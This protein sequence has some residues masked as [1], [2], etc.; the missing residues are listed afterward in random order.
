M[1]F[2][3]HIL[4]RKSKFITDGVVP[5]LFS[6]ITYGILRIFENFQM[7]KNYL[8]M[9]KKLLLLSV[10]YRFILKNLYSQFNW[11]FKKNTIV[12]G[13]D[14]VTVTSF[15]KFIKSLPVDIK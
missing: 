4:F 7:Q 13:H 10:F 12:V 6:K 15:Q 2:R 11:L 14:D 5:L 3:N 1:E 8:L 9:L